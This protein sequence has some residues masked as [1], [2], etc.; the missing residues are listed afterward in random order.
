MPQGLSS[1]CISGWLTCGAPCGGVT[2]EARRAP[3]LN[4]TGA[5]R[6]GGRA[7]GLVDLAVRGT[8]VRTRGAERG[9]QPPTV[10]CPA[11]R[12]GPGPTALLTAKWLTVGALPQ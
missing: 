6:P 8:A 10:P 3:G 11:V 1:G 2:A 7:V 9:S 4:G 12:P 5:G